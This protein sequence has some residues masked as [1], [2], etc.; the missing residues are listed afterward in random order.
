MRF[1]GIADPALNALVGTAVVIVSKL[2]LDAIDFWLSD[3]P[4]P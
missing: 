1:G 3:V 2:A 4:T